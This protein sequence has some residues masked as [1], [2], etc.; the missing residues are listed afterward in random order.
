MYF[1]WSAPLMSVR[2]ES[3]PSTKS[4]PNT[5][6]R[7]SSPKTSK[8]LAMHRRSC[9]RICKNQP[10][11]LKLTQRAISTR[12]WS[13]LI[14]GLSPAS[15]T[16]DLAQKVKLSER[17]SLKNCARSTDSWTWMLLTSS[18]E[19]SWDRHQLV[20]RC[21]KWISW[22]NQYPLMLLCGCSR[23]LSMAEGRTRANLFWQISQRTSNR[24][25]NSSKIVQKYKQ[26]FTQRKISR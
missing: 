7:S 3:T 8:H 6:H 10:I 15:F 16:S 13:K 23:K 9:C 21:I 1:I 5:S 14:R 22:V 17:K 26:S 11:L 24:S 4:T 12:P 18:K 2:R 25:K 19:R 20:S